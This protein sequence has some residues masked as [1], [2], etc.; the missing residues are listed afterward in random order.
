MLLF[1][2]VLFFIKNM[3]GNTFYEACLYISK[4]QCPASH[5]C[6][7]MNGLLDII[8]LI[9]WLFTKEIN[10]MTQNI[11]LNTFLLI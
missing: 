8:P 6:K 1:V 9:T 2:T 4:G 5:Y 11:D 3:C 7:I 10:N